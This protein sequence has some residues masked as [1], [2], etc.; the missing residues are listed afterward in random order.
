MNP[1]EP[2]TDIPVRYIKLGPGGAWAARCI[3]EGVLEYSAVAIPADLVADPDLDRVTGYYVDLGR[4]KAVARH[5]A[6]QLNAFVTLPTTGIW[7]TFHDGFLWW[8]HGAESVELVAKVEGDGADGAGEYG[9]PHG[10]LRRRTL[11]GWHKAS[12]A[13]DLLGVSSLSTRLTRVAGYQRTIC[14]IAEAD[15]LLRRIRGERELLA[16]RAIAARVAMEEVAGD[17]IAALHWADFETLVDLILAR[18]GWNR[19]SALGGTQK[20]ADMIVEQSVTGET[21]LVQVKSAASQQVLD[22]YVDLHDRT[23]AHDRLI[24]ACH[25]AKGRLYA[26]ARDDVI[27]WDRQG[28]AQAAIKNG[29]IDWLTTRVG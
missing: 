18:S 19:V 16:D 2:T 6:N 14:N 11:G 9:P 8:T 1:T 25:S 26:D 13:G 21:A 12:L 20:D 24:F 15:Y 3:S 27:L 5:S 4:P 23:S 22:R 7:I 10:F 29:L 28:L 17:M